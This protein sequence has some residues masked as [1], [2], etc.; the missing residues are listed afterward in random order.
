MINITR[1]KYSSW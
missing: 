1:V